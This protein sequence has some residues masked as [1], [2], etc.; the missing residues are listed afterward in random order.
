MF[1]RSWW[2]DNPEWPNGLE[3]CAGEKEYTG[4]I[5]ETEEQAI[6]YCNGFNE[7]CDRR[8]KCEYEEV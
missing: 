3:P 1:T 5:W 6:A 7:T 8:W 2:K 4:H